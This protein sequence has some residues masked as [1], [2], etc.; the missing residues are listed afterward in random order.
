MTFS[1]QQLENPPP[2]MSPFMRIPP[3]IRMSIL[4][5]CL[6]VGKINPYPIHYEDDDPFAAVQRKPDI[7][8]LTVNKNL[9]AEASEIFYG[10]NV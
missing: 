9:N 4:E 10:K 8:L 2:T 5:L 7:A 1:A 3:E 6:I